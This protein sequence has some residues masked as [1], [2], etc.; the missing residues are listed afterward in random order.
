MKTLIRTR[1]TSAALAV[2]AAGILLLSACPNPVTQ[3]TFSQ[4]TDKAAPI[5]D[6]SS[7]ASNSAYTQTVTVQ[8]TVVDSGQLR[9][10][11]Y[12]VTGTL[13]VLATGEVPVGSVG[14][15][16]SY[17]FQFGTI[18][19]SGPIA[20]TV[21]AKDWNDNTG[22][23]QV[24]LTSPGNS[25]SS[26]ALTASSKSIKASWEPVVGAVSSTLYYTTDGN[27]PN[28]G[29]GHHV[30][31][32][33]TVSQYQLDGLENGALHVFLLEVHTSGGID[34]WSGYVSAIPLS[35]FTLAP[36]VSGGY[37]EIR[38]EWSAIPGTNAF[39]VLR[40]T[41]PSGPFDNYSG[42]IQ[43][44]SFVDTL[45][46]DNTWYSYRVRPAVPGSVES[47]FNSAQTFQ[48]PP[49]VQDA[50]TNLP[51]GG[52]PHRV[53]VSGSY[54]YVAAGT[55]GLIVLDV[56][57][58]RSPLI[59]ATVATTNAK[60]VALY[61]NYAYVADG[62]GGMKV[63][64]IQTPTAP[65]LVTSATK[66]WANVDAI[67]IA[68]AGGLPDHVFVLD[69]YSGT[70]IHVFDVG[71]PSNPVQQTTYTNASYHFSDVAAKYIS[72]TYTFV[73][74][75]TGSFGT[76]AGFLETYWW[77][78]DT[79]IHNYNVYTNAAYYPA[80]VTVS[81]NYA[82]VLCKKP[83]T[84]EFPYYKVFTFD[85]YPS[86]FGYKGETGETIGD[87][88]D[89]AASTSAGK[90]YAATN[91]GLQLIDVSTPAAPS[92]AD[93]WDTPGAA[94]GVDFNASYCFTAS[95]ELGFQTIDATGSFSVSDASGS[96]ILP[97]ASD[98]AV[99]GAYAYLASAGSSS[100]AIMN[101][102]NPASIGSIGSLPL[103]SPAAI[104]LSGDFA[105]IADGNSGL[106]VVDI[107][108]PASPTLSATASQYGSATRVKVKGEH[109]YVLGT[110][111]LKIFDI[112]DPQNP[113]FIP[114][115]YYDEEAAM[116]NLT[117]REA[118]VFVT[119]G[120][121]FRDNN[122]KL[123]DISNPSTPSL[124]GKADLNISGPFGG[125]EVY[126][127]TLYG[128][129]A[130]VGDQKNDRGLFAVNVNPASADYLKAFGPVNTGPSVN[131]SATLAV[132][133]YGRYAYVGDT[134]SGFSVVSI[135]DPRSISAASL[136]KRLDW[137]S[138]AP[139][140]IVLSGKHAYLADSAIGLN[141]IKLF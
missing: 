121:Y 104:D 27:L 58:P 69:G 39:E 34:Y 102:S 123:I 129:Y 135:A 103:S 6:I 77:S 70:N 109:A 56:A 81:G 126:C 7:P 125:N 62:L 13:G 45:V 97:G 33:G 122:L 65:V 22:S 66:T 2:L 26:L 116:F 82:Y 47:T 98:V 111:G 79:S 85:I 106:R 25:I 118:R 127:V 12:T 23:A 128:D 120:G 64:D 100:L 140:A 96:Q 71:D 29:Y 5:I 54:A 46:S 112:S 16:G 18:T 57:D 133:A 24:T 75:T 74:L 41:S 141:I 60:D 105:F 132:A 131:N 19:F 72:P 110:T 108:N 28:Q 59:V 55:A 53:K 9:S 91:R 95:G 86:T 114:S 14:S 119:D 1:F 84:L 50:I 49:D 21:S 80:R 48:I 3:T 8:G 36:M 31:L 37:K 90:A 17:S 61:G 87:C 94:E 20:I 89:I 88:M 40:S 32:G 63:I 11:T 115:G 101:V 99:R 30:D 139:K 15:N 78:N 117:V 4:M 107:S 92:L 76:E 43:A 35:P 51:T 93:Y 44:T 124:V 83:A 136:L 38:L 68:A 73:Y 52:L 138:S 42:V 130:F 67:A 137:A 113:F 134:N 10:L